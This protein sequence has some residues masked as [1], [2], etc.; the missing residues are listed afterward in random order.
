VWPLGPGLK[1]YVRVFELVNSF[2][3]T[4]ASSHFNFPWSC[5]GPFALATA[6]VVTTDDCCQLHNKPFISP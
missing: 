5:H 2:S 1:S 6:A 4:N 3:S